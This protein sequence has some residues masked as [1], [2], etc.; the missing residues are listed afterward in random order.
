MGTEATALEVKVISVVADAEYQ[1]IVHG[2]YVLVQN[3]R[4]LRWGLL[5]TYMK[6]NPENI[7]KI[8]SIKMLA[9]L[10]EVERQVGQE[11]KISP[12][13][14]DNMIVLHGQILALTKSLYRPDSSNTNLPPEFGADIRMLLDV[15]DC[16]FDCA[17]TLWVA[18]ESE[19]DKV[20]FAVGDY[21]THRPARIDLREM[22]S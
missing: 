4:G 20:D 13:T 11:R 18:S 21:V 2:Y 8:F 12:A 16:V 9:F 15:G 7:G 1:G 17:T 3:D 22:C 14:G 19:Y 5:D 10:G 6:A